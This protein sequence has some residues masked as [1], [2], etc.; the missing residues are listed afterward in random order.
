MVLVSSEFKR[1]TFSF[2]FGD[3][4]WC[5]YTHNSPGPL[6]FDQEQ[7]SMSMTL[8][9]LHCLDLSFTTALP[10]M[11]CKGIEGGGTADLTLPQPPPTRRIFLNASVKLLLATASWP[12][13]VSRNDILKEVNRRKSSATRLEKPSGSSGGATMVNIDF[14][15]R[16]QYRI[17]ALSA[18]Q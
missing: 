17:S 7:V 1:S 12:G 18:Q 9:N 14:G 10:A 13:L 16:A 6:H 4:G 11:A 2:E 15:Q 5:K 3:L 8:P